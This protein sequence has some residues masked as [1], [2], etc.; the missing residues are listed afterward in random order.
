MKYIVMEVKDENITLEIPFLFPDIVVHAVA[1]EH[2][3][4]GL[5]EQWPKAKIKPISAG[6]V[7]SLDCQ[8]ECSGESTSLNLKS[9]EAIDTQLI[10]M[11][12]YGSIYA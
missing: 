1:A 7:Q 12:D 10:L 5:V 9:R 4:Y 8:V 2:I 3:G 11:S 6:M